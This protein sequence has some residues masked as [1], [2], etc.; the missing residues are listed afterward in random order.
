VIWPIVPVLL[1]YWMTATARSPAVNPESVPIVTGEVG[2]GFPLFETAGEY[3]QVVG[4]RPENSKHDI[5]LRVDAAERVAVIVVPDARP[6]AQKAEKMPHPSVVPA[7]PDPV[8]STWNVA[9]VAAT[10]ASVVAFVRRLV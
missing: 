5:V 3:A 9:P 8:P 10:L 6:L 1:L 2:A 4:S 7:P